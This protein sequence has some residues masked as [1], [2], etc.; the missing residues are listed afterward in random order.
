MADDPFTQTSNDLA[1]A[2]PCDPGT[3]RDYA[4]S[5]LIECHRLA[6]GIR[7][8]QASAAEQVRQIR[9]ER[10]ARRGGNRRSA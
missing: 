4:D 10:L 7:L 3:I 9:T 1:R 5:G 2:V 8:F 6:S